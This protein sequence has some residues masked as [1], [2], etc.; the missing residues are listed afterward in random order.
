M[1]EV[2]D[3]F[4]FTEVD[5]DLSGIR[6]IEEGKYKGLHWTFGTVTFAEEQDENGNLPC[7]FDYIIHDN[8]NNLEENQ[9]MLNFMG[10]ILMDV[11]DEELASDQHIN[12][13]DIPLPPEEM[14]K[15]L[16]DTK[17][18]TD[19]VRENIDGLIKEHNDND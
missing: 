16:L 10:D 1:T 3:I 2:K 19:Y 7:K 5:K 17:A 4:E 14:A 11:L 12:T 8:P 9:D 15:G 6:I 18:V 13:I